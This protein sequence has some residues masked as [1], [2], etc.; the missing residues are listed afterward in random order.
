M[1]RSRGLRSPVA[2]CY[3]ACASPRARA[4]SEPA[5]APSSHAVPGREPAPAPVLVPTPAITNPAAYG[6]TALQRRVKECRVEGRRETLQYPVARRR[7]PPHH[8]APAHLKTHITASISLCQELRYSAP[9]ACSQ[10]HA[11]SSKGALSD[12][13]RKSG[14]SSSIAQMQALCRR[15]PGVQQYGHRARALGLA[16]SARG[17]APGAGDRGR[18]FLR[19]M[20]TEPVRSG[21]PLH[22]EISQSA[23]R[24]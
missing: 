7:N 15:P 22:L 17:V 19:A 14:H 12:S 2:R 20:A 8:S 4:R 1:R 23:V 16:M 6:E 5:P 10:V 18:T 13:T 11:D 3:R 24:C 9:A 21:G